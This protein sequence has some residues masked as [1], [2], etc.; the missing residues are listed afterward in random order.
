VIGME[1]G[2]GMISYKGI[3]R[4]LKLRTLPG[5]T[6]LKAIGMQLQLSLT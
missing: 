5:G 4:S 6:L 2:A 1:A 3:L